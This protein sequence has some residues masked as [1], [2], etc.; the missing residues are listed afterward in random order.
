MIRVV[1]KDIPKVLFENQQAWTADLI[2]L[3]KLY[4]EYNKIPK[5]LKNEVVNKYR[6]NDI[7]KAVI[8]ITNG[9]CVFCESPIETVD[10]TNI[11]HFHAKSLYPKLTFKWSNLFPACRKCNIPKGNIDTKEILLVHPVLDDAEDFFSYQD[12]K[13]EANE[14]AP[15]IEKAVNTID[16]CN[17]MR[18][19]LCRVH[20][21][22]MLSFYE[23]EEKIQYTN[24][25][26]NQLTQKARKLEIALK[27]LESVDNLKE[28]SSYSKPYAGFLRFLI[29]KSS[30]IQKS[31]DIINE[32]RIELRMDKEYDFEWNVYA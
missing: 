32:N 4:G 29:K 10:Y 7:K 5:K 26:Y 28:Q 3:I 27:I 20:S 8:D 23:V 17:L 30:V 11:E 13:I 1:K 16:K 22:V 15:Q 9:K 21:N 19:S 6:H 18:I 14:N 12:L 2:N 31:M 25:H 24:D